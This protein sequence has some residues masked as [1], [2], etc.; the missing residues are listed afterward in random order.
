MPAIAAAHDIPY[1]ATACS[2][3]PFDLQ[4][5]VK[6]AIDSGGPAYIHCLSVCPTGW[7]IPSHLAIKYGRLAVETGIFP[8]YEVKGGKYRITMDIPKRRPVQDY[9][10]GQGRFRHLTENDIEVIQSRV[11][12]EYAKLT[13]LTKL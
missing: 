7:R 11:D 12:K 2:S 1:V 9:L 13:K 4:E 10:D 5:K 6:R 3:F 8:L